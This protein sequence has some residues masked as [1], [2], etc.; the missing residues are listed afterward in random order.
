M[1][2]SEE[3]IEFLKRNH[4]EAIRTETVLEQ[5]GKFLVPVHVA[6]CSYTF[7]SLSPPYRSRSKSKSKHF[8]TGT[9]AKWI[10]L[11]TLLF[12]LLYIATE[13]KGGWKQYH[14]KEQGLGQESKE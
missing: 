14:K 7:S 3:M 2:A 8:S 13:P 5:E 6:F 12:D 10:A 9:S 1:E 4:E 11:L